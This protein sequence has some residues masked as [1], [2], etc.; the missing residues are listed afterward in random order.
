MQSNLSE[1]EQAGYLSHVVKPKQVPEEE[2]QHYGLGPVPTPLSPPSLPPTTITIT[3]RSRSFPASCAP[4]HA[5]DARSAHTRGVSLAFRAH[6][7]T[8]PFTA[9][10]RRLRR[11]NLLA[12]PCASGRRP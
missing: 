8:V 6:V 11:K 9:G 7:R 2:E 10:S 4:V 3:S 5:S 12:L 1:D